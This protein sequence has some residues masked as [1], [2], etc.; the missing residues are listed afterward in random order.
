MKKTF[1]LS[2]HTNTIETRKKKESERTNDVGE[3][4]LKN[5]Y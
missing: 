3:E 1:L 5:Y 2:E 4:K